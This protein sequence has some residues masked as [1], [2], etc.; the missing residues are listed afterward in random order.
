M[1][2][3]IIYYDGRPYNGVFRVSVELGITPR[4]VYNALAAGLYKGKRISYDP[5]DM[6][7]AEVHAKVH[8][9]GEP[10]I[11]HPVVSG[12]ATDWRGY[13]E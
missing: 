8:H 11:Q 4:S 1:K 12:I 9:P 3:K 6:K 13:Y 7:D 10:L 2:T 5:G